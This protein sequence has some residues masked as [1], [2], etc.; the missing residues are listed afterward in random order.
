MKFNIKSILCICLS[1]CMISIKAMSPE[2]AN[3]RLFFTIA[4]TNN[5]AIS[6]GSLPG[7]QQVHAHERMGKSISPEASCDD[8]NKLDKKRDFA[9]Y[10]ELFQNAIQIVGEAY[11]YA[12]A[13][14]PVKYVLRTH[15]AA[16]KKALD[17]KKDNPKADDR[18]KIALEIKATQ[19]ALYMHELLSTDESGQ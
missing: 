6:L 4:G 5:S 9:P 15:I 10:H 16:E 8:I 2:E 12:D 18:Q 13:Q 7:S 17:E 19:L 3:K 11:H 14:T 1:I